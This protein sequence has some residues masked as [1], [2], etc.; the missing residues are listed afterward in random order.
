MELKVQNRLQEPVSNY[1]DAQS[2]RSGGIY[3]QIFRPV[4]NIIFAATLIRDTEG[5]SFHYLYD[6]G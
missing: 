4:I 3:N 1:E 5:F 6:A 2:S